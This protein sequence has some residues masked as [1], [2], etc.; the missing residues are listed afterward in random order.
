METIDFIMLKAQVEALRTWTM[1]RAA[2][3]R[4]LQQIWK[5]KY[6]LW[7]LER[8]NLQEQETTWRASPGSNRVC[9]WIY[10]LQI[11]SDAAYIRGALQE[12]G[13]DRYIDPTISEK[14]ECVASEEYDEQTILRKIAPRY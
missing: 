12:F 13:I 5:A 8:E 14:A 9:Q 3:D 10:E 11:L 1:V 2:Q 4:N 6:L 7:Q